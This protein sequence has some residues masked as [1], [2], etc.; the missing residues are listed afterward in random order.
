MPTQEGL[1]LYLLVRKRRYRKDNF[2][3]EAINTQPQQGWSLKLKPKDREELWVS[4]GTGLQMSMA[5]W[6]LW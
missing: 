4:Q 2:P 5:S 3:M 6:L 1:V